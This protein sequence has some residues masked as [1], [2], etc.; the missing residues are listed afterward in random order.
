MVISMNPIV[1]AVLIVSGIGLIAGIFLALANQF[2]AVKENETA[3]KIREELPGANCGACGFSGCSGYAEALAE[4]PHLKTGLCV[5]GGDA[6]AAKISAILG[7]EA[8]KTIPMRAYVKCRGTGAVA[9]HTAEYD[10]ISSCRAAATVYGGG[11][12]CRYGCIGYGDCAAVCDQGAIRIQDG[13]AVIDRSF[14]FGCGKCAAA[15]PR[16]LIAVLPADT[17]HSFVPCA[18]PEKG[19]ATKAVC[20][21]GCLGCRLC[22]KVCE[23]GAIT[24][25]DNLAVVDAAKC[26]GCGKCVATC[27]FGVIHLAE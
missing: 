1:T 20:A 9:P 17:P 12:A 22:A 26:T 2:M 3:K 8:G 10:G 7:V 11:K 27:K 4:K 15:C 6:V 25:A 14:C 21:A 16:K 18:N 24:F 5:V 13:V 23:V 19:P